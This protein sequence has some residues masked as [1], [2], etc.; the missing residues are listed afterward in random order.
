MR[1]RSWGLVVI[2]G[3]SL[4]FESSLEAIGPGSRAG[5]SLPVAWE[6]RNLI[7]SGPVN[8]FCLSRDQQTL[9]IADYDSQVA[10]WD[11][12]SGQRKTLLPRGHE[13]NIE[14][15]VLSPDER[16]LASSSGNSVIHVWDLASQK[17]LYEE[18]LPGY[19]ADVVWSPDGKTILTTYQNGPVAQV[20]IETGKKLREFKFPQMPK[21][22]AR[23]GYVNQAGLIL[24]LDSE[25]GG[26]LFDI[27]TGTFKCRVRIL[28][29]RSFPRFEPV[30]LLPLLGEAS[31]AAHWLREALIKMA[32]SDEDKV[33]DIKN[34]PKGP[35]NISLLAR[36]FPFS[37]LPSMGAA[38]LRELRAWFALPLP[39]YG[40]EPLDF[41]PAWTSSDGRISY[42]PRQ[43]GE[44]H[45]RDLSLRSPPN[46]WKWPSWISAWAAGLTSGTSIVLS[47][48]TSYE[49]D[50]AHGILV[51]SREFHSDQIESDGAAG[52]LWEKDRPWILTM[53]NGRK[54]EEN[55]TG[56]LL[57]I[58]SVTGQTVHDCPVYSKAKIVTGNQGRH[59]LL[60]SQYP[61]Q[62]LETGPDG[63]PSIR[64]VSALLLLD[65]DL[66]PL[67][68]GFVEHEREGV[69]VARFS[70]DESILVSLTGEEEQKGVVR[71]F[72]VEK[73]AMILPEPLMRN[74]VTDVALTDQRLLLLSTALG[75]IEGYD[76]TTGQR[77]SVVAAAHARSIQFL[78]ISPDNRL[79][80]SA[81]EDNLVKLWSLPDLKPLGGF[82]GNT[83]EEEGKRTFSNLMFTNS[84]T[85]VTVQ[86]A[87]DSL[88]LK[89][90]HIAEAVDFAV[91]N[92][93]ES[94][95]S[96][97]SLALSL[98]GKRVAIGDRAGVI[99]IVDNTTGREMSAVA[100][101]PKGVRHLQ[102]QG[103]TY[104]VRSWGE[105]GVLDWNPDEKGSPVSVTEEKPFLKRVP[106]DLEG[107]PYELVTTN[108]G[109]AVVPERFQGREGIFSKRYLNRFSD[110]CRLGDL[111]VLAV[112]NWGGM[113][114]YSLED[115]RIFWGYDLPSRTQG[116]LY[117]P[118]RR[119]II[120]THP[121]GVTRRWALPE[122]V[123]AQLKK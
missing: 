25:N 11:V 97:A 31:P 61:G 40:E 92:V 57:K 39:L 12:S 78:A 52:I 14:K 112:S 66:K 27:S 109:V 4:V 24:G 86:Y 121:D 103:Q 102:F 79:L 73:K 23:L 5:F 51:S 28:G 44:I 30:Q 45:I 7:L 19:Y 38:Q 110:V 34:L 80:A 89:V 18:D 113:W 60:V 83:G 104:K 101:Q 76:I 6:K 115:D 32:Q 119:E 81:G 120:T 29:A 36:N 35:E 56:R 1:R 37:A 22:V 42:V 90:H 47:N 84:S 65:S 117:D 3:F 96:N 106:V 75:S 123:T 63:R 114:L 20:E 122:K 58:D 118:L 8:K 94:P 10:V 87:R 2:L 108:D 50:L 98:D 41:G 69:R 105:R 9:F 33:L 13:N 91:W 16:R 70:P 15:L 26:G 43:T 100:A 53:E 85:L 67:G 62:K 111:P 74:R 72:D 107:K 116:L 68:S 88:M 59:V 46:C 55:P 93:H 82:D 54:G 95:R 64:V 49:L 99:T 77:T 48:G 21:G 71:V 17:L